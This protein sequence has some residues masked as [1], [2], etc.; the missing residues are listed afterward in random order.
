MLELRI[1][2][3][4][5][6]R[7]DQIM[8][9]GDDTGIAD[10]THRNLLISKVR[11]ETRTPANSGTKQ[12]A[13]ECS[14]ISAS[15]RTSG[16]FKRLSACRNFLGSPVDGTDS[17]LIR[18]SSSMGGLNYAV[19]VYDVS[20][21]RHVQD[22]DDPALRIPMQISPHSRSGD[23][24]IHPLSNQTT[25]NWSGI[26]SGCPAVSASRGRFWS[27]LGPGRSCFRVVTLKEQIGTRLQGR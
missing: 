19:L 11:D 17:R 8:L 10:W 1:R 21:V 7:S 5:E 18:M 22:L 9:A 15:D 2:I 24:V 16:V 25:A 12:N 3:N 6:C 4:E 14:R 20:R 26:P 13:S 27:R 23:T